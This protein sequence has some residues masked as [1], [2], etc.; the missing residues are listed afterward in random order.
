[1]LQKCIEMLHECIEIFTAG[2]CQCVLE[3]W[4]LTVAHEGSIRQSIEEAIGGQMGFMMVGISV[5]RMGAK[6]FTR[7]RIID[8]LKY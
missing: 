6:A 2:W 8:E 5:Q 3:S 1:M 7:I 4:P